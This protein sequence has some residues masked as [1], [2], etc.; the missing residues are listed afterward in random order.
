[1]DLEQDY[2]ML[3]LQSPFD[4]VEHR[5]EDDPIFDF[6]GANNVFLHRTWDFLR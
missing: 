2:P 5:H 4:V 1:M 6:F 3:S